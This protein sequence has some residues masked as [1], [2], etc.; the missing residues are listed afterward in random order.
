MTTIL[1]Y[2]EEFCNSEKSNRDKEHV[3]N[4]VLV[5]TFNLDSYMYNIA[6]LFL[7]FTAFCK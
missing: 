4:T 5:V 1:E 6:V 2:R 7:L 3:A